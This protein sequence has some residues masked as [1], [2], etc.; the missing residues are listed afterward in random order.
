MKIFDFDESIFEG[1]LKET[2]D[3]V[4]ELNEIVATTTQF[5]S[6]IWEYH[7]K[8]RYTQ[9]VQGIQ[10]V[11]REAGLAFDKAIQK[12]RNLKVQTENRRSKIF[13]RLEELNNPVICYVREC[14]DSALGKLVT[15]IIFH[16]QMSKNSFTD[17]IRAECETN[18]STV[19]NIQE[20]L[21]GRRENLLRLQ[22]SPA[23][24]ILFLVRFLDQEVNG[25]DLKKTETISMSKNDADEIME[26]LRGTSPPP[27]P[28]PGGN[29]QGPPVDPI[30]GF[31]NQKFTKLKS[32]VGYSENEI[33][34][35]DKSKTS[36]N[37]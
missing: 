26:R 6:E 2:A 30:M 13:C 20:V 14:I 28:P 7:E 34:P 29:Y 36:W 31:L 4:N 11:Q 35:K 32:L 16:R 9:V 27:T 1:L 33:I 37:K 21:L 17:Q 12:K 5:D 24:E 3:L 25:R 15:M 10:A 22:H 18:L 23:E 19:S 8:Y